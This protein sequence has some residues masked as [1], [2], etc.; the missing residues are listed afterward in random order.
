MK[1]FDHDVEYTDEEFLQFSQIPFKI[2]D[3]TRKKLEKFV[4]FVIGDPSNA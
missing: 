2:D 4:N 1:I 3:E